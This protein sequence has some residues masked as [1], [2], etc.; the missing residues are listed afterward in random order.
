M[1][2]LTPR[3]KMLE[4]HKKFEGKIPHLKKP[5]AEEFNGNGDTTVWKVAAALAKA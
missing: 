2:E 3:L 5:G 4:H 1:K